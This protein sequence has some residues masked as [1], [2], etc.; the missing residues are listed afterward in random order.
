MTVIGFGL[1]RKRN[2]RERIGFFSYPK[3]KMKKTIFKRAFALVAALVLV[4]VLFTSC[5]SN[6]SQQ[7]KVEITGDVTLNDTDGISQKNLNEIA[8]FLANNNEAHQ[9]IV[10]AYRGYNYLSENVEAGK[11]YPELYETVKDENGEDVEIRKVDV[12][13]AKAVLQQYDT[14]NTLDY[15]KLDR[16]DVI[17]LVEKL[18]TEVTFE[19]ERGLLGNIMYGIGAALGWVTNT[20]G[21]G[22]Y[23]IGIFIFAILLEILMLPMGIKTQ[24][25]SIKQASLRP[26]EMAIRKKYAGRNDQVTMQKLQSEI[27]E[28]YRKENFNP[29]SGCLPLL[30]QLPVIMILYNIVVDPLT[31]VIGKSGTFAA[32]LQT[33]FRTSPL[34]GGF[35]G[36]LNQQKGNG[37]IE[38]LSKVKEVGVEAFEGLKNFD[39]FSNGDEVFENLASVFENIPSF[40]IGPVNLG[41]VPSFERFD[42]LLLVPVLTFVVYFGSMKITKKFMYQPVTEQ[43]QQAGCS[44]NIMDI[45][46]PLMSVFFTFMV[47]AAIGVYWMFKSILST[48]EKFILA[49]LM[50]L[51]EFTEEDF[52]AAEKE[53]G[54]KNKKNTS[55][56][57]RDPNAPRP[58]S[59]HYIDDEDYNAK[60]EEKP[61]APAVKA[62]E[63][64]VGAAPLKL[65]EPEHKSKKDKKSDAE[66][67]AAN[68]TAENTEENK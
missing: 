29:A 27:Q 1:A 33:Y 59:L 50:P 28:M 26:K 49:K 6:T 7:I 22:N 3:L 61:K 23:I 4:C 44:N 19:T 62:S 34:A 55:K 48:V 63:T 11:V 13:A 12:E 32:A 54:V 46:M 25:N 52:K 53:M 65:D 45:T 5:A 51:P 2:E 66:A 35:G 39:L 16:E 24:K 15:D 58:R 43:N 36:V 41:Y 38:V 60:V 8:E 14:K 42:W 18:K 30:I 57:E 9:G 47:P 17:N 64:P 10:A 67:P 68:E 37:S 20:L 40:S 21:F 31:H 56:A